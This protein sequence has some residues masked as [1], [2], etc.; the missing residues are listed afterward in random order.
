MKENQLDIIQYLGIGAFGFLAIQELT[1][2]IEYLVQNILVISESSIVLILWLPKLLSL[3]IFTIIVIL[4]TY[5]LK[6][7]NEI[8]SRKILIKS[9]FSFIF[10]TIISILYSYFGTDYLFKKFSSEFDSYHNA[11][12][13]KYLL[14]AYIAFIPIL[15][16]VI[17][18]ILILT[19]RK[20]VANNV[21]N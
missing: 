4:I 12:R 5:K 1:N 20:T 7:L 18:G 19:Y 13:E 6:K 3:I 17:F 14:Q 16:Y 15:E 21:Y 2:L 10:I 11:L 9:I 8:D